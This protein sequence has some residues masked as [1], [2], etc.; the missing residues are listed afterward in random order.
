[1]N[2]DT[3]VQSYKVLHYKTDVVLVYFGMQE[4]KYIG[5]QMT[6]ALQFI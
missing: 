4:L 6:I 3:H 1:M 2:L 5:L